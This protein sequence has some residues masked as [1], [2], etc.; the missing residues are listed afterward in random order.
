MLKNRK[1]ENRKEIIKR[2]KGEL[3]RGPIFA[4]VG[5]SWL[6]RGGSSEA[7]RVHCYA[8]RWALVTSVPA[9]SRHQTRSAAC[10]TRSPV[11]RPRGLSLSLSTLTSMRA[12]HVGRGRALLLPFFRCWWDPWAGPS[13]PQARTRTSPAGARIPREGTRTP[14]N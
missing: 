7:R 5:P 1:R 10:G 12:T 3:A 4:P 14:T 11:N 8:D 9:A 2:K 6:S 13:S